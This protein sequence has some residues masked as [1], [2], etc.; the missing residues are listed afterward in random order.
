MIFFFKSELLATTEKSL[1]SSEDDLSSRGG[2]MEYTLVASQ[3]EK[4]TGHISAVQIWWPRVS[5]LFVSRCRRFSPSELLCCLLFYAYCSYQ[6][7][8][9]SKVWLHS[10]I[11]ASWMNAHINCIWRVQN[12]YLSQVYMYNDIM[13]GV[14][15]WKLW[16]YTY[17]K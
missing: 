6:S 16:R 17:L 15:I 10:T 7:K 5:L 2:L 14:C 11:S 12:W 13:Y 9:S 1:R 4:W 8:A 3:V